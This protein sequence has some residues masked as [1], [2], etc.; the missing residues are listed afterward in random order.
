VFTNLERIKQHESIN[1]CLQL[2]VAPSLQLMFPLGISA[3]SSAVT[4]LTATLFLLIVKNNSPPTSEDSETEV[5]LLLSEDANEVDFELLEATLQAAN[6]IGAQQHEVAEQLAQLSNEEDSKQSTRQSQEETKQSTRQSQ[7]E[8]E[9]E[10]S[11]LNDSHT[12]PSADLSIEARHELSGLGQ[13]RRYKL[14]LR[15]Q[16]RARGDF[17]SPI[18]WS[19]CKLNVEWPL[20]RNVLVDVWALRRLTPF[21]LSVDEELNA[22]ASITAA[23]PQWSVKPRQPDLEVG[24]YDPK[25]RPFIVSAQVAFKTVK[26]VDSKTPWSFELIIPDLFVRY[27]S[28]Q[29]G[30]LADSKVF[31]LPPPNMK[32][33]CGQVDWHLDLLRPLQVS[34][35]VASANNFIP[36]ATMASVLLSSVSLLACLWKF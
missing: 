8:K 6:E 12:E 31:Y 14:S 35:P 23:L 1:K 26:S 29:S 27:Q 15:L 16:P 21:T 9:E 24:A 11:V 2:C 22:L 34:L 25:A 36:H 28:A 20:P 4:A 5:P 18:D 33:D 30:G 17:E 3:L 13:H 32:F 7:V 19:T 10:I